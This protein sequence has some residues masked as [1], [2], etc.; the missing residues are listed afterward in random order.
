MRADAPPV[1]LCLCGFVACV[2]PEL[3]AER[4]SLDRQEEAAL[5]LSP[6]DVE[7]GTIRL[8]VSDGNMTVSKAPANSTI[9]LYMSV[10]GS[11]PQDCTTFAPTCIDLVNGSLYATAIANN[12]GE[13]QF[14]LDKDDFPVTGEVSWQPIATNPANGAVVVG[15]PAVRHVAIQLADAAVAMVAVT[16]DVGIGPLWTEGNTHTGGAIWIDYNDDL[17]PDLLAVNGSGF[18]N[19]LFRND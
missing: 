13:A 3:P 14:V 5:D 16:D 19:A 2:E 18:Q 9:N 17:L 4:P 10:D 7:G 11:G 8:G 15:F 6:L 1:W 12:K